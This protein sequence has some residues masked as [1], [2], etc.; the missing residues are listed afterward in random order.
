MNKFIIFLLIAIILLMHPI[1]TLGAVLLIVEN[2][3]AVIGFLIKAAI[4]IAV[5]KLLYWLIF[6]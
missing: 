1:L 5:L 4:V 2:L 6:K 3:G